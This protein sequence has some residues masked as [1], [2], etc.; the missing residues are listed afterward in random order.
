MNSPAS[1]Y[2]QAWRH[3]ATRSGKVRRTHEGAYC[4]DRVG[5]LGPFVVAVPDDTSEPKGNAAGVTGRALH[6]VKGNL[7]NLFRAN[8]DSPVVLVDLEFLEPLRLPIKSPIVKTFKSL[9]RS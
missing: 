5:F 3:L 7:Y 4:I 1:R 8:V 2:H 6:A 9:R